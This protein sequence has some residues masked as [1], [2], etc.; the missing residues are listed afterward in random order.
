[1]QNM[2]AVWEVSE[3]WNK[4]RLSAASLCMVPCTVYNKNPNTIQYNTI[5]LD[6]TLAFL[7]LSDGGGGDADYRVGHDPSK[8]EDGG[9]DPA[10]MED[11]GG[12]DLDYTEDE[13]GHDPDNTEEG[14]HD[15]AKMEDEGGHNPAKMEDEGGHDPAKT[16]N[17]AGHNPTATKSF[18][19]VALGT[20]VER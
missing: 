10:K 11:E 19:M 16:E 4:T 7:G 12:H 14:G 5:F 17:E 15:P 2:K 18:L 3:P 20:V 6:T 13:G 8:A 9:H 1:M